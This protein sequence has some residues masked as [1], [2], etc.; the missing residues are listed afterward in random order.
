MKSIGPRQTSG[1]KQESRARFARILW[2]IVTMVIVLFEGSCF[3]LP[4]A[5]ATGDREIPGIKGLRFETVQF[6]TLISVE[7]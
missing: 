7:T 1:Q 2:Q 6:A 5:N 4:G 3:D